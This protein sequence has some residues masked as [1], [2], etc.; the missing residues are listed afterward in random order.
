MG[1]EI[2]E[3]IGGV[4]RRETVIRIYC[5]KIKCFFFPNM[6][7]NEQLAFKRRNKK[8]TTNV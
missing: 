5:T 2:R 3:D 6:W 7:T 1:G 8:I 4:V